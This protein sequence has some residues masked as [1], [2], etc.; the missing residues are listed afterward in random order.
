MAEVL[1]YTDI[2]LYST[3]NSSSVE[4]EKFLNDNNIEFVKLHYATEHAE[5]KITTIEAL[6]TWFEDP[7]NPGSKIIFSDL[8]I[9]IFEKLYWEAEDKSERLEK[10]DYIISLANIASDFI[11][12]AN[13]KD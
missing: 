7:S 12:K 9:L 4:F 13:K 10:R 2:Y 1:K 8:P 5:G 6:N 3:D 11:A